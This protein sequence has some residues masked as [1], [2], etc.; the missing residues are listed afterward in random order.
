MDHTEF[1]Q[2]AIKTLQFPS[3]ATQKMLTN[4]RGGGNGVGTHLLRDAWG[5][6]GK[7]AY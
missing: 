4:I 1:F 5:L 2:V 3:A 7:E 6:F